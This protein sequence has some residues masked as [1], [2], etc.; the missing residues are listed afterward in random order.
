MHHSLGHHLL[1]LLQACQR[2]TKSTVLQKSQRYNDKDFV[3][4]AMTNLT[5]NMDIE[6]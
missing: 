4:R 3:S 6:L 1:S 2:F 5:G